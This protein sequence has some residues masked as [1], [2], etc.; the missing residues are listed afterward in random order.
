MEKLLTLI[1][2]TYNMEKYLRTCLGSLIIGEWQELLEVLV[3]NDGS[4]DSSS[5]IAHE[6]A[7][8]HPESFHVIDK[9][10]GNYG[11]CVNRG[12]KEA[13]GKYVKVLD[14][15]D[16]FDTANFENY[17]CFLIVWIRFHPH[18]CLHKQ[19]YCLIFCR[20]NLNS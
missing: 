4:K 9:E 7:N 3:I 19:H 15:D 14:A 13:T 1:I 6:Y 11:S 18:Y 2:P 20:S 10:N 16:S 5:A 17:L 8:K 12:L